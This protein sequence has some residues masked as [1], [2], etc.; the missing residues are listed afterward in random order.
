MLGQAV[1]WWLM[2]TGTGRIEK[3]MDTE[4]MDKEKVT[5]LL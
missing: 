3:W 2:G 5:D 4:G 1:H